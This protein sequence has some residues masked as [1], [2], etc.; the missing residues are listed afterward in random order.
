M[1]I[2]NDKTIFRLKRFSE[3]Y[4]NENTARKKL[5]EH[6]AH[7]W[8]SQTK[9]YTIYIVP[10]S[11]SIASG[12]LFLSS[13]LRNFLRS[14]SYVLLRSRN[15]L[16]RFSLNSVDRSSLYKYSIINV[17]VLAKAQNQAVFVTYTSCGI[18]L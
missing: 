7:Y 5:T 9:M 13:Y 6:K 1:I 2:C 18:V 16:L 10:G 4:R 15:E 8:N 3:E 14:P 12:I 17:L 11:T